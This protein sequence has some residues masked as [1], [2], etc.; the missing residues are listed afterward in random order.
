MQ[1]IMQP[2]VNIHQFYNLFFW[3]SSNNPDPATSWVALSIPSQ[4]SN[5]S[6][7]TFSIASTFILVKGHFRIFSIIYLILPIMQ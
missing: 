1:H 4:Q 6:F 5:V 7:A 3:H 2:D